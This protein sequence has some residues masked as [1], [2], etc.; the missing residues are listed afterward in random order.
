MRRRF[1]IS[2]VLV[3]TGLSTSAWADGFIHIIRDPGQ[4]PI[5]QL[6]LNYHKVEVQID[7]Q[8][9]QTKVDEEFV[10]PNNRDLEGTY[11]FPVP[12]GAVIDKF[13]MFIDGREVSAELLDAGK[14][15]TVYEDI[16]RKMKDPALLEYVDRD[17]FK[18]RVYPIPARG[19]KRIKLSYN[20]VLKVD[21]GLFRYVYPLNTERFSSLPIPTV[22]FKLTL[23]SNVPIKNVYSPTHA[24]EISRKSDHEVVVGYEA[25][26][27]KP[28]RD[29]EIVYGVDEKD[30]GV[31]LLTCKP[32]GE[33]GYFLCL[34]SPK[35]AVDKN[36][37]SAKDVCFILD[38]SGS[39]ADNDKLVQAK[40]SLNFCL[41]NLSSKDRFNIV[42]FAT[43]I[44]PLF[45]QLQ[46]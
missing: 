8:V 44:D 2:I 46:R 16:V 6:S 1:L 18:V 32:A 10:N 14:A 15:R 34:L 9:V 12:K 21:N 19:T 41:Q 29:I 20:E 7:N 24:V 11:L 22:S 27:I 17:L 26:N 31:N 42:R 33:D 43:G 36:E 4:P 45:D 23:K 3:L 39:M 38:T 30:L 13:S 5:R 40:K 25:S 37:E 35:F 28:D